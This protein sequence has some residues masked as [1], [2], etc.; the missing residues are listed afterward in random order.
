M[1]A[2]T[3]LSL[4]C[5]ILTP[6]WCGAETVYVIDRLLA[7][8][9]GDKA[10]NSEILKVVPSGT[11]LDLI[12][13]NGEFVEVRTP[14]GT[15]G[16]MDS[17]Y[18]MTT[19]PAQL[20][21][22]ELEA[23]HKETS[24][25]LAEAREEVTALRTALADWEPAETAKTPPAASEALSE[26]QRL[27]EEVQRLKQ[28]LELAAAMPPVKATEDSANPAPP[29]PRESPGFHLFGAKQWSYLLGGALLLLAFTLGAY[30][31]DFRLRKRYG[32]FRI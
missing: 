14:D 17:G 7:G 20:V 25:E 28:E 10:L 2:L 6:G 24:S 30:V 11:A 9:H 5:A 12:S 8:I 1:R 29:A 3:G 13:R 31:V 18:V 19:R 27:A 23:R 32:G 21:V 22:L 15:A 26:M 16:W 4:A